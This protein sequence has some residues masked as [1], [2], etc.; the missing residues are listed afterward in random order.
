[1]QCEA[2]GLF[3]GVFEV[4][5]LAEFASYANVYTKCVAILYIHSR[6]ARGDVPL[7]PVASPIGRDR[8]TT[9]QG[10]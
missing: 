10:F 1:N 7:F 8:A 3:L 4:L 9:N 6:S 2:C 5:K